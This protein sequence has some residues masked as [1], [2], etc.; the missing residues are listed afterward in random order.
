MIRLNGD[1]SDYQPPRRNDYRWFTLNRSW[2][3]QP[4]NRTQHRSTYFVN[5]EDP[6]E[7]NILQTI[8]PSSL[9]INVD[10]TFISPTRQRRSE[11]LSLRA[12]RSY[13]RAYFATVA[14]NSLPIS[15]VATLSSCRQPDSATVNLSLDS[16]LVYAF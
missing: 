3:K 11:L 8:A 13:D 12:A 5:A 15:I 1:F 2:H 6:S 9:Q 14:L 7:P 10:P 16:F 4:S